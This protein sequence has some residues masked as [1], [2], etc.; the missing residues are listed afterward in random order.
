MNLTWAYVGPFAVFMAFL[1]VQSYLAPLGRWEFPLR[2]VILAGAIWFFSRRILSFRCVQPVLSVLLG[3]AVF[4]LWVAPDAL[5]P[6]YRVHYSF[7]GEV[8]TSIAG[9]FLD[10]PMVLFFRTVRAALI[11]PIVEELFWRGWLMRWLIKPEFEQ[12]P[13][14][15][16]ETRAFWITA[17]LFA[18]EHGPFWDVGL[19]C[20]VIYNWWMVRT[21]SL[22]DMMLVHGVTNLALSLYTIQTQQWQFWL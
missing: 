7:L 6:G 12:V 3:L 20:G 1:V 8:K 22:G 15:T 18:S 9:Q 2:V 10:D 16:Y 11:V 19:V 21:K 17:L 4:V 14:G 5:F 13:L